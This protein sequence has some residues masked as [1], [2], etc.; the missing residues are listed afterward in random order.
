MRNNIESHHQ[1]Q[2]NE[3][4]RKT[5][6]TVEVHQPCPPAPPSMPP[7]MPFKWPAGK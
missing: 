4:D 1:R 5:V 3:K 6:T 2:V 7:P